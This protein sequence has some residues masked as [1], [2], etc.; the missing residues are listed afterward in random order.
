MNKIKQ[1]FRR[2]TSDFEPTRAVCDLWRDKIINIPALSYFYLAYLCFSGR[3]ET[4]SA[5]ELLVS[6]VVIGLLGW[7]F[8]FGIFMLAARLLKKRW[9]LPWAE[10]DALSIDKDGP[11]EPALGSKKERTSVMKRIEKNSILSLLVQAPWYDQLMMLAPLSSWI[12]GAYVFLFVNLDK[13]PTKELERD[14]VIFVFEVWLSWFLVI[15]MMRLT[16][17]IYANRRGIS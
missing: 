7:V 1:Y 8:Y 10:K 9:F 2:L 11:R 17:G 16:N 5:R 3:G 15:S 4:A 12:Y 13:I 6:M 14:M